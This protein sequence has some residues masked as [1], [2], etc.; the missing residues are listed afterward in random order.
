MR[1][2]YLFS[3]FSPSISPRSAPLAAAL[4]AALP[5]LLAPPAPAW[6]QPPQSAPAA[7]AKAESEKAGEAEAPPSFSIEVQ[8]DVPE[9]QKLLAEHNELRRYQ[10]VSDLDTA[11]LDR[12]MKLA[13]PQLKALLA[14]Q[15]YFT[16]ELRITRESR[17]PAA[18]VVK[19]DVK[20]GPQAQVRSEE[21]TSELQSR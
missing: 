3:R 2:P 10:Q 8:A 21:H 20:A 9:L 4:L 18:P 16:P 19:V 1:P 6:A 17:P 5:A 14:A 15:G 7:A 13:E 12:L 11:E